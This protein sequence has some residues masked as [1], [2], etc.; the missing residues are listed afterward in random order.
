LHPLR[1]LAHGEDGIFKECPDVVIDYENGELQTDL[2][3]YR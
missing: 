3:V 1:C 2:R